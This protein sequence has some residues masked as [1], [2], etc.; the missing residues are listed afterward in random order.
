MECMLFIQILVDGIEQMEMYQI[1]SMQCIEDMFF[2]KRHQH[3][4]SFYY[5]NIKYLVIS[6][7]W[8]L[9]HVIT[10]EGGRSGISDL[11]KSFC[12]SE[13]SDVHLEIQQHSKNMSFKTD[14]SNA[15]DLCSHNKTLK[16]AIGVTS[17][18]RLSGSTL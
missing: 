3:K 12:Y 5:H 16:I 4:T 17:F 8:Q 7:I 13:F 10:F 15:C 6:H 11:R 2:H 1:L 14:S 18:H 9:W